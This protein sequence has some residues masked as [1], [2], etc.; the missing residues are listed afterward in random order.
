M[1]VVHSVDENTLSPNAREVLERRYLARDEEGQITETPAELWRRVAAAV[2]AAESRYGAEGEARR[3]RYGKA[4]VEL[5]ASRSF[6]PN[7]P[8][9]MNAGRPL[10]QL[11]ACFV[12]PVLDSLPGIFDSLK[13]AALIHQSGGGTGFA[14]SRLRPRGAMVRS[15]SGVA[16][17]PVSFL[18]VY[19]GATEAIKQ[20]GCVVADTRVATD[21]GLVQIR[22]LGPETALAGSWYRRLDRLKVA[23]DNSFQES[24]EFYHNGVAQVRRLRTRHGYGIAA[25]PQHRL[26]VIDDQGQYVWRTLAE[27]KIGDWVALQKGTYSD[28]ELC[29]LPAVAMNPHHNAKPIRIPDSATPELGEFVGYFLGDGA[30]SRNRLILTVNRLESDIAAR[31]LDIAESIFGLRAS[32]QEKPGDG[33]INY[34]FSST[35]LV[36]WLKG[37]GVEK[38]SSRDVRIPEIAFRAGRGFACAL[39]R[40]LFSADGHVNKEGY[41]SLSSV[42]RALIDDAQQLLL[43]VGIPS[44]ISVATNRHGAFG[45]LPLHRLRVITRDGI[46]TF[47]ETVGFM[48]ASKQARLRGKLVKSYEMNDVIPNQGGLLRAAYCGPG[49]GSAPGRKPRGANRSLYR[50]ILHYISSSC[51]RRHLTRSR[52]RRL[53][54]DHPAIA[55]Q[56]RLSWLLSNRQFYDRVVEIENGEG[57]TL[58]LSVPANNTYIA[59]GFVSHN[60]RRGANMGI[61]RV[62]HPDIREFIDVKNDPAELTNFNLSVGATDDFMVAIAEG[63]EVVLRDPQDGHVV[64]TVEARA[65][66]ERIVHNAWRTGDPGLVFLDRINAENP[67][68][69]QGPIEATNPCGEQPLLPYEACNLGSLNMARFVN[70]RDVDW[71]RLAEAVAL[72][73]RFLDDVIDVNRYPLPEIDAVVKRN[74]KVGLGIM[75]FADLLIELGIAYDSEAALPWPR[76]SWSSSR[77]RR[78]RRRSSSPR[79][80][81]PSRR[82]S[83]RFTARASRGGMPP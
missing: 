35:S 46:K 37:I 75:G 26:R 48:A 80:G 47:A 15:S 78:R 11:S 53:A 83:A 56:P 14:F 23:T 49:R 16:S 17:G 72:G 69:E 20:G 9:L 58:D 59:N 45:R 4:F 5:L 81:G 3:E 64:E 57:L 30:I 70:G 13:H 1:H 22:E 44:S 27:I 42:S 18:R 79:S 10:A 82:S 55:A 25:T 33:S 21:R 71:P 24:D 67:T 61:L 32:R 73:I 28:D 8:T 51:S 6:L 39:L 7:S 62:D 40:G 43:W 29:R 65:L 12:L 52:L 76:S 50:A 54:A 41:P 60:T 77:K 19:N 2:A 63:A 68:P 34:F 66:F 74:R 36:Q 38:S 31:L